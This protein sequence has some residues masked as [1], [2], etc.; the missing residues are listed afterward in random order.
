MQHPG[1]NT[2]ENETP[3]ALLPVPMLVRGRQLRLSRK[4]ALLERKPTLLDTPRE[5]RRVGALSYW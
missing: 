2:Y 4:H 3:D 5:P 1:Q